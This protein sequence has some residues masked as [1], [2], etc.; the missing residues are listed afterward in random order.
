MYPLLTLAL[1]ISTPASANSTGKTGKSTTG[2]TTCHGTAADTTTTATLSA[3]DTEVG[4]GDAVTVT[5]EVTTTDTSRTHAGLN[6]SADGGTLSAGT[7]T[8]VSSSEIT[9]SA[10]E[11]M[12][13]STATFSFTWTAPSAAGTYTLSGAGTAVNNNSAPTGDG[14]DL[15]TDV[16]IEVVCTDGDGDGVTDCDGDCDDADINNFPGNDEICDGL[17]NDCDGTADDSPVDA[18]DWYEDSDG[19]G[20]GN[21]LSTTVACTAPTGFVADATDCDDV[22]AGINP[23]SAEICDGADRDEDCNGLVDDDDSGATGQVDWYI[24]DDRDGY[25][26]TTVGG[27]ACDPPADGSLNDTDCDDTRPDVN[28]RAEESCDATEDLNC[29]GI[30]GLGDND[31]DGYSA[32]E[33][34]DDGDAA[35]NPGA[36]EVC[37]GIDDNCDEIIDPSDSADAT[38]WYQDQDYDGYGT[39]AATQ[40]ACDEPDG[41]ADN[42]EDCNDSTA[43]VHPGAVEV[44][45]DGIDQDCDGND[46]DWD[47]DGVPYPDDCDDQDASKTSAA[48]CEEPDTAP[49]IDEPEDTGEADDGGTVAAEDGCGSKGSVAFFGLL[50]LGGLAARRRRQG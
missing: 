42:N 48:D 5:F 40:V 28:P 25:G 29:D 1:A 12:S 43:G 11:A 8:Q 36:T 38:T 47:G 41:Y 18:D 20:Y 34:C 50:G 49:I 14:W 15:A 26:T 23:G 2:C 22:R 16:T 9:H 33:E 35:V 7:N 30:I 17:D 3:S 31:G 45:Y 19:D 6:V 10:P 24:D 21:P 13:S 4:L 46:D 32:C 39:D 27:Q 44:Y 37:N